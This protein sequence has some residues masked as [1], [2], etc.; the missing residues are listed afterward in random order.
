MGLL[1]PMEGRASGRALN[2]C[3]KIDN[4]K[5]A[6]A[7]S[8]AVP[9]PILLA[10]TV[11]APTTLRIDAEVEHGF[12]VALGNDHLSF[13]AIG[14]DRGFTSDFD[15]Y[16]ITATPEQALRVGM[17]HS[18]FIA[19]APNA[20]SRFD[21]GRLYLKATRRVVTAGLFELSSIHYAEGF[22]RGDLGG[23]DLQ[24]FVHN[25]PG[26]NGATFDDGLSDEYPRNPRLGLAAGL[27]CRAEVDLSAV[28]PWV[29]ARLWVSA[30]GQVAPFATGITKVEATT[31]VYLA[32]SFS[33][34]SQVFTEGYVGTGNAVSNDRLLMLPGGYTNELGAMW[35]PTVVVGVRFLTTDGDRLSAF[36]RSTRSLEGTGT[37]R[38]SGPMGWLVVE[39]GAAGR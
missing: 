32:T 14:N 11:V 21:I 26:I 28:V 3:D 37:R 22:Y 23:S 16:W 29:T 9:G 5:R 24:H 31:G 6:R 36:L 27:G 18:V 1:D 30:L 38:G 2:Q 13:I 35:G 19:D 39:W 20:R 12:G 4:E 8:M 10:L 34:V 33:K 17:R 25:W 15:V 7:G